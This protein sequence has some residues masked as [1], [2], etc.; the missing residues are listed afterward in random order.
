M[1]CLGSVHA[2]AA[3]YTARVTW[4]PSA[5]DSAVG[6]HVYWR[7]LDATYGTPLDAGMPTP[8]SDGTMTAL[9]DGLDTAMFYDFAV[10][11]YSGDGT[12]SVLSN[13][14][15]YPTPSTTTTTVAT[16]TTTTTSTTV[17]LS[18]TVLL[19]NPTSGGGFGARWAGWQGAVNF[20][21]GANAPGYA[22]E[23]CA[24]RVGSTGGGNLKCG[25]YADAGSAPGAR[26]CQAGAVAATSGVNAIAL[27][28]P[29]LQPNT[30]YWIGMGTD[31]DTLEFADTQATACSSPAA[32]AGCDV[33]YYAGFPAM[34]ANPFGSAGTDFCQ[35]VWYVIAT[36]IGA[37]APTTTTTS[38]TTSSTTS[39][40]S[41]T[42]TTTSTTSST[43]AP[44]TTTTTTT[45]TTTTLPR[46][47]RKPAVGHAAASC[48]IACD[49]ADGCTATSLPDGSACETDDPCVP[50][51]CGGGGCLPAAGVPTGAAG[52]H[53]LAVR[54]FVLGTASRRQRFLARASFNVTEAFA[55][56]QT[57]LSLQLWT[58]DGA[59][60]YEVTIPGSALRANATRTAF[61]LTASRQ[62][63]ALVAGDRLQRLILRRDGDTVDVLAT[64]TSVNLPT[65]GDP[66][67]A[68]WV[69][70]LGDTCVRDVDLRCSPHGPRR[71]SCN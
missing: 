57:G 1:L 37:P 4:Q 62:Q 49:P 13:E 8:A 58:S 29:T 66:S 45:V 21:T 25:I 2:E 56:D 71:A 11:A 39:T 43:L 60:L 47:H 9:V 59:D 41:T 53:V 64:G 69:L 48:T 18:G 38:S 14:V 65:G 52:G 55:P 46:R 3:T 27:A 70:R 33:G 19:G 30:T 20:T 32:S 34:M 16:P 15:A 68:G 12:E 24:A 22:V 40:T 6:Y 51:T 5:G 67:L 44:T 36:A 17:P 50:G 23:A 42:V 35:P 31:S 63:D 26:L 7:T 10:A 61:R 28:C 54:R